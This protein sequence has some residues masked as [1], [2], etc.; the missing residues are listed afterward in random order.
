MHPK[1]AINNHW[2][3]YSNVVETNNKTKLIEKKTMAYN[4][5]DP[6]GTMLQLHV[7]QSSSIKLLS[8]LLLE[9]SSRRQS[10]G[11]AASLNGISFLVAL[12]CIALNCVS[13][14]QFLFHFIPPDLSDLVL[15]KRHIPSRRKANSDP[16]IYS[17]TSNSADRNVD[18][19]TQ[20]SFTFSSFKKDVRCL[21]STIVW[22]LCNDKSLRW[23]SSL[24][25]LAKFTNTWSS[26]VCETE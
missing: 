13:S 17:S 7:L 3:R 9:N 21:T 22:F 10:P 14:V 4:P 23:S 19:H 24:W 20:L 12:N 26:V 5:R 18:H 15:L 25:S 6:A 2:P 1:I 11:E 16:L 8:S